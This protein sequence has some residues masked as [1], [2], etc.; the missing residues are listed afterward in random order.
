MNYFNEF[1][2]K[3]AQIPDLI[4]LLLCPALLLITAI[5]L[6]GFR[7]RKLYLPAAFVF[8][9]IGY[10]LVACKEARTA[11][12]WFA[13]YVVLAALLSLLFF[14]PSRKKSGGDSV[15][16]LYDKFHLPLDEA[17]PEGESISEELYD[18]EECGL[19]LA[20]VASLLDSLQKC[21]LSAGDR[22]EIDA[23]ARTVEGY[24]GR[25]LRADEMCSLNDCL[26]T[27]LKMTAKYKL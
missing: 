23:V 7:C 16:D 26:A 22:L 21:G 6:A 12:A 4:S 1:I 8:G 10:F 5:L 11:P 15:Q 24:R 25:A 9:G 27:I 20:H 13:L 17:D 18:A 19:R 14:I 3:V 2:S